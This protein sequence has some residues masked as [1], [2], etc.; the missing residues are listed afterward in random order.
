MSKQREEIQTRIW[1][2]KN[3]LSTAP[4]F[5]AGASRAALPYIPGTWIIPVVITLQYLI[6]HQ[7]VNIEYN[8]IR[9]CGG[10][11][12]GVECWGS[13]GLHAASPE[14]GTHWGTHAD[15]GPAGLQGRPRQSSSHSSLNHQWAKI[16]HLAFHPILPS[17]VNA[18]QKRY[19]RSEEPVIFKWILRY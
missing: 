5:S 14:M 4:L 8:L 15:L 16:R 11:F 7:P 12:A 10:P 6:H 9:K 13:T 1:N 17:S 19:V 3:Y 18:L 2:V